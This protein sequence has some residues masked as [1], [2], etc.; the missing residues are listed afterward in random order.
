MKNVINADSLNV[1]VV[2]DVLDDEIV[3]DNQKFTYDMI[4][5]NASAYITLAKAKL[6]I[7]FENKSRK[8]IPEI[9][10]ICRENNDSK[11]HKFAILFEREPEEEAHPCV[12]FD[13]GEISD[14]GFD[15]LVL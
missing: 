1:K 12:L 14:I 11:H 15:Y 2:F 10:Y 9:F 3:N 8:F 13:N 6:T 4:E 7:S 5:K